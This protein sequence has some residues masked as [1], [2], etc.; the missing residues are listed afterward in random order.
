VHKMERSEMHKN[1][2]QYVSD[3]AACYNLP[4]LWHIATI[5]LYTLARNHKWLLIAYD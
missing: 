1:A 4:Q 2:A 3:A 5:E